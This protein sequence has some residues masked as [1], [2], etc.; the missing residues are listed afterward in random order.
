MRCLDRRDNSSNSYIHSIRLRIDSSSIEFFLAL[1]HYKSSP[2]YKS[3]RKESNLRSRISRPPRKQARNNAGC[4]PSVVLPP[5]SLHAS[6]TNRF[7]ARGMEVARARDKAKF[8]SFGFSTEGKVG[9]K[10]RDQLL[11]QEGGQSPRDRYDLTVYTP[12][13]Q[14]SSAATNGKL[15]ESQ[16]ASVAIW[17]TRTPDDRQP[18]P[19]YSREREESTREYLAIKDFRSMVIDYLPWIPLLLIGSDCCC[20]W[21]GRAKNKR[22]FCCYLPKKIFDSLFRS[23]ITRANLDNPWKR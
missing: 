16:A 10:R 11:I 18:F 14:E 4:W 3:K 5:L 15:R 8:K 9:K 2:I 13:L 6:L 22:I 21:I 19:L 7:P 1:I 12:V 17:R 20:R 23:M